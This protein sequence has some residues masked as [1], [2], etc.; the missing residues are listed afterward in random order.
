MAKAWYPVINYEMCVECGSCVDLCQHGVYDKQKAPRPVVVN[1]EG[2]V[3]SCKGYGNQCPSGAI[4]YFGDKAEVPEGACDCE[5]GCG[6]D[7]GC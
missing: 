5:G 2:C 3:Q 1:P 6:C 7:C 4:E